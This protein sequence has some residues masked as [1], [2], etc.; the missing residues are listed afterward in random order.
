MLALIDNGQSA[1][2]QHGDALRVA[3]ANQWHFA[4]HITLQVQLDQEGVLAHDRKQGL[5]LR[6]I[7]HVRCFV[8]LHARQ[9]LG[10]DH[11]VIVRQPD[12]GLTLVRAFELLFHPEHAP[13]IPVH[14]KCNAVGDNGHQQEP[15]VPTQ[16]EA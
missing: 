16:G 1:V 3:P 14:G 9:R 8:L 7:G 5:G 12:T 11:R 6:V 10:I 4:Q 13:R 15:G 2:A